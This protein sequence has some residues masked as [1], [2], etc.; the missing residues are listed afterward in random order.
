M[1]TD[2]IMKRE[3]LGTSISQKSK[4]G[5]ISATD[6]VRAGNILRRK[7]GKRDFELYKWLNNKSTKEFINE[8]E[9]K[10]GKAT[11]KSNSGGPGKHTWLH[12]LLAIDLALSIDPKLKLEV[13]EWLYDNLLE[14]R[15]NSG[16]SYKLMCGSLWVRHGDH[17]TFKNNIKKLALIIQKKCGV[18]N[19]QTATENQ[20][21]LRDKIHA[22]ITS[23]A[24]VMNN[25]KE[26]IRLAFEAIDKDL[27]RRKNKKNGLFS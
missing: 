5:F 13:Y 20:L 11:I 23:F 16:D 10:H 21:K 25:N 15:N 17:K 8:I 19:W 2:V 6:I 22:T 7:S 9:E 1:K 27:E 14:F 18:D 24:D 3:L 26:A 12:P 4:N